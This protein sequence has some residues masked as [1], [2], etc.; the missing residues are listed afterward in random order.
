[1]HNYSE[2]AFLAGAASGLLPVLGLSPLLEALLLEALLLASLESPA[3]FFFLPDLKSVSYQPPP[4]KRN[5]AAETFFF[6][7]AIAHWG[8]SVS[9]ASRIFCNV[10]VVIRLRGDEAEVDVDLGMK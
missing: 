6:S 4:V 8:Q 10:R 9:A 1:M 2:L 3:K 5:P 7:V